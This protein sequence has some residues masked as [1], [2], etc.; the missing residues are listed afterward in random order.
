M[1]LTIACKSGSLKAVQWGHKE[2]G[3]TINE[4]RN[5]IGV[6]CYYGHVDV[7]RYLHGR[8][9]RVCVF[10]FLIEG[11]GLSRVD[12]RANDNYALRIA[13]RNGHVSVL[14]YLHKGFGLTADDARARNN[15]AIR[16]ACARGHL[17]ILKYL[18][19]GFGL[20]IKDA[21]ACRNVHPVV[22]PYLR[23]KIGLVPAERIEQCVICVEENAC[24]MALPCTHCCCGLCWQKMSQ[25][26][27]CRGRIKRLVYLTCL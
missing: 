11:F 4:A 1:S 10:K 9:I 25:C 27:F 2:Q 23:E 5:A 26:P 19:E 8:Y 14:E 22:I 16:H 21:R 7:L 12:A 13:C 15:F 6:A 3:A 18:C 24:V 20:T 17:S